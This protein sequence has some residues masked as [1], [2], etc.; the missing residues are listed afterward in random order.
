MKNHFTMEQYHNE[1]TR[2]D[3]SINDTVEHCLRALASEKKKDFNEDVVE[4]LTFEELIGTLL[5]CRDLIK[6][7]NA[8]LLLF[9]NHARQNQ[10]GG[11]K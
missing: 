6:E 7:Y 5:Q 3:T 8:H 11:E 4:N 9:E 1:K 10:A 2:P